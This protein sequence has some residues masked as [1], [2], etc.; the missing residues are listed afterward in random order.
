MTDNTNTDNLT[1]KTKRVRS[2]YAKMRSTIYIRRGGK[3][4]KVDRAEGHALIQAG[5]ATP[6]KRSE[7]R[8]AA[9]VREE[10]KAKKT[11]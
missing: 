4:E 3:I 10:R 11:K 9:K 5:K 8:K 7:V 6:M 2:G 1:V